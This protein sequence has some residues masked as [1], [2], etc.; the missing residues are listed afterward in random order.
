[1]KIK[2]TCKYTNNSSKPADVINN[3]TA[4]V[5]EG[6]SGMNLEEG[7]RYCLQNA[8][9]IKMMAKKYASHIL[10]VRYHNFRSK[11]S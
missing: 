1:M 2:Y 7:E 10:S 4:V 8:P 5:A 11:I 6:F 9:Y 3:T